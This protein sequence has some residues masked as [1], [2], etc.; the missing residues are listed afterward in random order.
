MGVTQSISSRVQ[1]GSRATPTDRPEAAPIGSTRPAHPVKHP[2]EWGMNGG[3]ITKSN[4]N[5]VDT[6]HISG[7]VMRRAYP[8]YRPD[9]NQQPLAVANQRPALFGEEPL[10][11]LEL[12]VRHL[13]R[14]DGWLCG[15]AV[16]AL[17]AWPLV[18]A[19]VPPAADAEQER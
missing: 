2:P 4:S 5:T 18:T 19:D 16:I 7:V 3:T 10:D 8:S 17:G 1:W 15:A 13:L 11:T 9:W 12:E 14:R 6:T